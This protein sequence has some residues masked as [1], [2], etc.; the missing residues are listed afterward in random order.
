[1]VQVYHY[2]YQPRRDST[3]ARWGIAQVSL[4]AM[5]GVV[6][7]N[8]Q[9][10]R[11][12]SFNERYIAVFYLDWVGTGVV[13]STSRLTG[14]WLYQ[15]SYL[16]YMFTALPVLLFFTHRAYMIWDRSTTVLIVCLTCIVPTFVLGVTSAS[17]GLRAPWGI[18]PLTNEEFKFWAPTYVKL[19]FQT[20]KLY[21]ASVTAQ[22]VAVLAV[23][24]AICYG[25]FR[26]RNGFSEMDTA[27]ASLGTSDLQS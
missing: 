2:F 6:L 4:T 13:P 22:M 10:S 23:C 24:V 11:L 16:F 15:L 27:S 17:L 19:L 5:A 9:T 12:I 18:E 26:H 1:M 7:S 25:I 8:Y 21:Q 3:L 20:Q 14:Q